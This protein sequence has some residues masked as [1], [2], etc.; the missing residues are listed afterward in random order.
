[1]IVNSKFKIFCFRKSNQLLFIISYEKGCVDPLGSRVLFFLTI[2]RMSCWGSERGLMCGQLWVARWDG[3]WA[4]LGGQM[5]RRR[6][7]FGR[8]DG[9]EKGLLWVTKGDT[10]GKHKREDFEK[11]TEGWTERGRK[12]V[13]WNE[14]AWLGE[15]TSK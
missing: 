5:G 12:K 9:T 10:D 8:P 6:G 2:P 15:E 4:T 14:E 7:C 11:N 1:M 13:A 3:E